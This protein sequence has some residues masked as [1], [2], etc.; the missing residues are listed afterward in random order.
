MPKEWIAGEEE[1]FVDSLFSL[2]EQ[3]HHLA[4]RGRALDVRFNIR[5]LLAPLMF[6]GAVT[7]SAQ[8]LSSMMG[9]VAVAR[10]HLSLLSEKLALL[11]AEISPGGGVS[12]C[13]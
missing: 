10:R 8:A 6:M 2:Q 5:E 11:A 7:I 13:A 9:D 12:E 1:A 4:D 3:I